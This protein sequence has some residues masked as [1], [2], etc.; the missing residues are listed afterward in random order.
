MRE[1]LTPA[2]RV[3]RIHDPKR[4]ERPRVSFRSL[5]EAKRDGQELSEEQIQR[6]VRG[7][8]QGSIPDYQSSAMLMA[9]VWQGMKPAEITALTRAMMESGAV[10]TAS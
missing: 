9:I 10:G 5:I 1:P 4:A 8:V 7:V 6:F 2:G 3:V